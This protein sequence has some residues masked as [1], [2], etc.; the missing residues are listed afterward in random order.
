M[1][2]QTVRPKI[3]QLVYGRPVR[4][5]EFINR[6]SELRT[7]F[8]R[9]KTRESTAIVGEAK[10]GKTSLLLKVFHPDTINTYLQD[11]AKEYFFIFSDLLPIDPET[12][13]QIQFWSEN[14]EPITQLNIPE[15][16][17]KLDKLKENNYAYNALKSLFDF[18]ANNC[19]ITL[20][21]L[22]D[23]FDRLLLHENF[24]NPQF[25]TGLRSLATLTSGLILI[26]ASHL[27]VEEMNQIGREYIGDGDKNI[28]NMLVEI[29]LGPFDPVSTGRLL[30]K[31][32]ELLTTE[33][34]IFI[35]RVAGYHPF[36]IQALMSCIF[37]QDLDKNNKYE[38][39][40]EAYFERISAHFE[41]IWNSLDDN[42]RT[43]A[44]ILSLVE[45]N[46]KARGQKYSFREIEDTDAFGPELNK[47]KKIGLA[48]QVSDGWQFDAEHLMVWRGQKWTIKMLSFT[49]W[50]RDA[51]I[52][53]KRT[54]PGY[55][56]WLTNKRYRIFLTDQQWNTLASTLRGA[57]EWAVKGV[58][59]L[60]RTLFD[61]I[62]K[63]KK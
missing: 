30:S 40:A 53:E 38:K 31:G 44:V 29:N 12:Y 34:R 41:A 21:L 51:V 23:E 19:N 37:E 50:I 22:L 39:A 52:A 45:L 17:A 59:G 1:S 10:I 13:T 28:L 15:I 46:G 26:T 25:Y 11:K 18:L 32:G 57:P 33:D 56:D 42:T 8:D 61:E 49:W 27:N 58:A 5:T 48:E 2:L 54:I 55:N 36:F 16:N 14:L 7:I 3:P 9:I 35:T 20:V 47:L 6:E 63:N 4:T 43:A 60:A 62:V 24:K